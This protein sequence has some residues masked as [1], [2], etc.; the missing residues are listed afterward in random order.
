MNS[1]NLVQTE[2]LTRI[3]SSGAINV[4][5]LDAVTLAVD[6]GEFLGVT[7]PSGCG[8]STLMNLLGGLDSPTS[9]SIRVQ[10][11]LIGELSG[12]ELALYRRYQ[13]GMIFQSFNLISSYT[14]LENVAFPLLF[15]GVAKNRRNSRAAKMLEQ[16]GLSERRD[17]RP[18]ELSG[19]EQQRVAIARA[20]INRPKILLA[21]EPTGNTD[22]KTSK[23]IAKLLSE[24]NKNHGLTIIMISHEQDLL[25]E[26]ADRIV[27]L[28]DGRLANCQDTVE[29]R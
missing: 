2:N 14:A 20:L 29:D 13:V 3:Y 10:D 17:H 28:R 22:S 15:A 25:A 6:E 27:Q 24:L 9:G 23:Q 16:V 26:F 19:G 5:A 18:S 21:D 1:E 12:Q 11:R 7:G 4:V 8:K